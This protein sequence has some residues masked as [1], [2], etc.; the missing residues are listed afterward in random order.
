VLLLFIHPIATK[1][2]VIIEK[3][4]LEKRIVGR[5]GTTPSKEFVFELDLN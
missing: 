2:H 1:I 4:C 5:N 3:H